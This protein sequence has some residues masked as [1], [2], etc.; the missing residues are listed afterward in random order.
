MLIENPTGA[1]VS[2]LERLNNPDQ[3]II[4]NLFHFVTSHIARNTFAPVVHLLSQLAGDGGRFQ[5]CP[6]EK[7]GI[8]MFEKLSHPAR[9]SRKMENLARAPNR[10]S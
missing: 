10:P 4:A 5:L 1:K 2:F 9:L 8:K 7:R 6:R 3:R